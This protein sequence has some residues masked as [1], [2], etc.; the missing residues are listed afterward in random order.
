MNRF[1]IHIGE[2]ELVGFDCNHESKEFTDEKLAKCLRAIADVLDTPK[3]K[4]KPSTLEKP[5]T[6]SNDTGSSFDLPT[7]IMMCG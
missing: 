2:K 1:S 7:F 3:D 5:S 4:L 6:V